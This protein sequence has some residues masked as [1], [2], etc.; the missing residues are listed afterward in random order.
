M[1]KSLDETRKSNWSNL[2][3]AKGVEDKSRNQKVEIEVEEE[4]YVESKDNKVES[5]SFE[6]CH[7]QRGSRK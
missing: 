6:T 1:S 3:S 5:E 7:Q 2:S 4:V